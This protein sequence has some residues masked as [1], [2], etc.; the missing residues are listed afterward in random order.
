[1]TLPRRTL[2]TIL[3]MPRRYQLAIAS[4]L[5]VSM[6][7][8]NGHHFLTRGLSNTLANQSKS[9]LTAD[10]EIASTRPL[11]ADAIA[12]ITQTLPAHDV[13]TRRIFSSMIQTGDTPTIIEVVAVDN[14]YPLVGDCLVHTATGV[15]PIQTIMSQQPNP[16]VI[17]A[18]LAE[19]HGINLGDPLTIGRF[20]GTV[21]GIV[22]S[23]PDIRIQSV[24]YG[25]RVYVH[26][27]DVLRMGF[28]PALS[29]MYHS[30]F[31][32]LS[33]PAGAI[34]ATIARL[35]AAL[36]IVGNSKT[37]QGSYGPSQPIVVRGYRDINPAMIQGFYQ[38]NRF[39]GWLS[40]M[41]LLVSCLAFGYIS[42]LQ[43]YRAQAS[44][45]QLR[46]L[47][48]PYATI[49]RTFFA[50][51]LRLSHIIVGLG[52]LGGWG[53][54]QITGQMMYAAIGISGSWLMP[55]LVDLITLSA[56]GYV[57]VV[58]TAGI[59][60]YVSHH[61][62]ASP[63]QKQAILGGGMA[64]FIALLWGIGGGSILE[65]VW[66][67]GGLLVAIAVF[68]G[69]DRLLRYVL[70]RLP[71]PQSLPL[72]LAIIYLRQA[73]AL[74]TTSIITLGMALTVIMVIAHY[75]ASLLAE[76]TP[77]NSI[78]QLFVMDI[79]PDQ[80]EAFMAMFT[81]STIAPLVRGRIRT[82]NDV[83]ATDYAQNAGIDDPYFLFREQNVSSRATTQVGESIRE[84]QWFTP[85]DPRIEM[86]IEE[87]FA[88]QLALSLNDTVTFDMMGQP[89]TAT[90]TSI[91]RVDWG[92]FLPNFFM[93]IEP[94][95][96]APF[97]Q[98]HVAAIPPLANQP[99][100][101]I[102]R[103]LARAFPTVAVIDIAQTS[104]KIMGF[105]Q[106]IG[107]AVTVGAL[108]ATAIGV[109]LLLVVFSLLSDLR[110][111][112]AMQLYWIGM[113]ISHIHR[114]IHYEHGIIIGL[115]SV[116]SAIVSTISYALL[117]ARSPLPF[118]LN[119]WPLFLTPLVLV[120]I[121]SRH[122]RSHQ[123]HW[124]PQTDV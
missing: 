73:Q 23:E 42:W 66:G 102:K 116:T 71:L 123:Q 37:I 3:R 5:T 16:I 99:L 97:P 72:R 18:A 93:I 41:L 2:L 63:R 31:I 101:D 111:A 59:V 86:S 14:A 104:Q 112:S 28:D 58:G 17:A 47:G 98:T 27:D 55:T 88:N 60:G 33:D 95:Y 20:T 26:A 87:R 39:F 110:Q 46:H 85:E 57:T 8:M 54:A 12:A 40:V 113:P 7:L 89:L 51:S 118:T 100:A 124:T 79:Y 56:L 92:T 4:V 67:L 65:F 75:K 91:R 106:I 96:L 84:G 35:Q 48:V 50:A 69:L 38:L 6:M 1:M 76:F 62:D 19:V 90:I 114:M 68:Y 109:V 22:A 105:L 52:L 43:R 81:E 61:S 83:P 21:Q 44:I 108:Y 53:L 30:R 13:A 78:P 15:S 82:I 49:Q 64:L 74:R 122:W 10:I 119:P 34:D 107:T 117:I 94:P 25:P 80:K 9:L 121:A 32:R 11:S 36:G 103:D 70:T 24:A 120:A 77:K 45:D 115:I 29:R